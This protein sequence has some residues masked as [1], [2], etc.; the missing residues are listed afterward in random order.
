MPPNSLRS[1]APYVPPVSTPARELIQSARRARDAIPKLR[2]TYN[3]FHLRI[4]EKQK[5]WA[6]HMEMVHR[7][8]VLQAL[9]GYVNDFLV[10]DDMRRANLIDVPG[11]EE[12]LLR[13]GS[14]TMYSSKAGS[15]KNPARKDTLVA[16]FAERGAG[17]QSNKRWFDLKTQRFGGALLIVEDPKEKSAADADVVS[18]VVHETPS[19]ATATEAT[20]SATTATTTD[21]A[22][23]VWTMYDCSGVDFQTK[24]IMDPEDLGDSETPIVQFMSN[25]YHLSCIEITTTI[26]KEDHGSIEGLANRVLARSRMFSNKDVLGIPPD[27]GVEYPLT[28]LAVLR[29][30]GFAARRFCVSRVG[31][32]QELDAEGF[33]RAVFHKDSV[34]ELLPVELKQLLFVWTVCATARQYVNHER[35]YNDQLRNLPEDQRW[36]LEEARRRAAR[37]KKPQVSLLPA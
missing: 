12:A 24:F 9:R 26:H 30:S 28:P 11:F 22:Q 32:D 13:C 1:I 36:R 16:A 18:D 27:N 3:S 29:I 5:R 15:R 19:G 4:T 37:Y 8:N 35:R 33:L 23:D 31:V 7:E 6:R 25:S 10:D 17:Q 21:D 20:P 34:F 14:D 2:Q